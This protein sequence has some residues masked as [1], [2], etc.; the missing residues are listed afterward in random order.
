MPPQNPDNPT[1]SPHFTWFEKAVIVAV[2]LAAAVAI[3]PNAVDADLWGHVQYGRDVLRN[4]LPATTTYS[5]TANGYRWINHENLAEIL[6]AVGADNLGH[7]GLLVVKSLLGT[8]VVG[9]VLLFAF[10][11]CTI[12]WYAGW[13]L[14]LSS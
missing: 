7:I 14:G 11:G 1:S 10:H 12:G 5:Y 8:F 9:M 2:L 6:L 13:L 3:S 4:G